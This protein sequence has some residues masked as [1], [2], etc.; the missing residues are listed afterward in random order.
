[1]N[2][3][4]A[5]VFPVAV[6]EYVHLI[7][8]NAGLQFPPWFNEGL[9]EVYSTLKP[10]GD[11]IMVGAPATGRF[12]ALAYEKWIPLSVIVAAGH[13]SPYYNEKNKAGSLYSEGWLLV[14]MLEL[15]PQY[16]PRFTDF[17]EQLVKGTPSR[18]ALEGV[19]GKPIDA[20][21]KDLQGYY[22]RNSYPTRLAS[23]KL[24]NGYKAAAEPAAMFDVK[25]ALL[26][27]ANR[28]GKE[29]E[30]RARLEDLT[31]DD[32]K[33]P[34]PHAGLA[35]LAWRQQRPEEAMKSF[36]EAVDL[37]SRNPQMLWD[38]GRMA[39]GARP[40]QAARALSLLLADQP[41]R[42]DVRLVLGQIQMSQKQAKDAIETLSPIKRVSPEE[43]P[44]LFQIMAYANLEIGNRTLARTYAQRWIE[45]T[46]DTDERARANQ[47][48]RYLDD[49]AK[50]PARA[51]VTQPPPARLTQT[52]A[53]DRPTLA[54]RESETPRETAVPI[55]PER[56][57]VSGEFVEFSCRGPLPVFVIQTS[58]GRISLLLDNPKSVFIRGLPDDTIDLNCGPQ[59]AAHVRV[60]YDPP[61][62]GQTGV[63]GLARVIYFESPTK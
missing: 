41:T 37:G 44:K 35:Y 56:P 1:M 58:A 7:A 25:L 51:A 19:Y 46:Q 39:G 16:S 32:P 13:D 42:M 36:Q 55:T 60:E 48:L 29:Q 33:R 2:G 23:V 61:A 54:R 18:Q 22:R 38:Y 62:P 10:V 4:T 28:P 50:A 34:E 27:L 47:I 40:A 45:N 6:H 63:L 20:I 3:S 21:D 26:D 57:S 49:L 9:A 59:K 15:D 31:R 5:D 17:L 8:R 30:T 11:Q 24:R 43:A 14:H 12:R 52:D 53:G